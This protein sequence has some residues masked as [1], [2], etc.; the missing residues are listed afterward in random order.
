MSFTVELAKSNRSACKRCKN[1]IEKDAVRIGTISQM[2][3]FDS[4]NY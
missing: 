2:D 1:K 3:G 4:G